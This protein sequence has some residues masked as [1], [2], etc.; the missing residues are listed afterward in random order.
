MI[1][2][3]GV[4]FEFDMYDYDTAQRYES[5]LVLLQTR[6]ADSQSLPDVIK[7]SCESVFQFFDALFGEGAAEK[8]FN[9]KLNARVCTEATAIVIDSAS[10]Q[11]RE[12][13]ALVSRYAPNA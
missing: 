12:Y 13:E 6:V 1:T 9:G 2:V 4:E 10:Q 7:E 8:V 5:A 11:A 3:N